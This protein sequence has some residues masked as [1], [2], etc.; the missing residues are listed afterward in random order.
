[1]VSKLLSFALIN[2]KMI[3]GN[4]KALSVSSL[5]LVGETEANLAPA[6]MHPITKSGS[7]DSAGQAT[8]GGQFVH[9]FIKFN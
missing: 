3:S 7:Y 2:A 6:R 4:L 5:S 8:K 1:M 9:L